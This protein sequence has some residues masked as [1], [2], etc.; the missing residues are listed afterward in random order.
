MH[1]RQGD[2]KPAYSL[3]CTNY[4]QWVEDMF[5]SAYIMV[6]ET[7]VSNMIPGT[8]QYYMWGFIVRQSKHIF[9]LS[10]YVQICFSMNQ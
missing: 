8:L 1:T 5:P 2:S 3:Q 9:S 4:H 10:L 6:G 7:H